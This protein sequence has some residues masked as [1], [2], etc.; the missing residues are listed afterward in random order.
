MSL[1]INIFSIVK[2]HI[3]TLKPYNSTDYS[4][5]DVFIF[6]GI[7][8]ILSILLPWQNV[9]ITSDF[10]ST[11]IDVFSIL[12]GL[13]LN[14]LVLI[15]DSVK[16]AKGSSPQEILRRELLKELYANVSYCVLLAVIIVS[17][18]LTYNLFKDNLLLQKELVKSIITCF[19]IFCASNFLLSLLMVLKRVN[20]I[21]SSEIDN[22]S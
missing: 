18:M 1:K 20:V 19:T 21:L 8:L 2:S 16:Q 13:L 15:F 22:N 9:F 4:L 3:L 5:I 12:A 7:P 11:L 17:T 14:L 10:A 6:Y